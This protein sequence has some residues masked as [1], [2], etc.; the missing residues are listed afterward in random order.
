MENHLK[1]VA[2]ISVQPRKLWPFAHSIKVG[3]RSNLYYLNRYFPAK[4]IECE[5]VIEPG[6]QK[7]A[8]LMMIDP[9]QEPSVMQAGATFELRE[10]PVVAAKC[11]VISVCRL[12][13]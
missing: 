10:G 1:I 5:G 3:Y 11:E 4:V 9:V 8:S 6:E 13:D 12:P 7:Q 2:R